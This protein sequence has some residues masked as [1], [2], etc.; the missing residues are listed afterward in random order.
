[1]DSL[2]KIPAMSND[3]KELTGINLLEQI[4]PKKIKVREILRK[5]IGPSQNDLHLSDRRI[6]LRIL[7]Y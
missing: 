7:S 4:Q 1:M 2:L 3:V 6:L 5:K